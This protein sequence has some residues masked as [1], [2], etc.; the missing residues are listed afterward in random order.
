MSPRFSGCARLEWN[1]F[2]HLSV[3]LCILSLLSLYSL[4][5]CL[6]Y[7]YSRSFV[8]KL[9]FHSMEVLVRPSGLFAQRSHCGRNFNMLAMKFQI[10]IS[11]NYRRHIQD[12]MHVLCLSHLPSKHRWYAE[13]T[14]FMLFCAR[15]YDR[16]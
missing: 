14:S 10:S 11:R 4:P 12:V 7:F 1:G 2:D 6:F 9:I 13:S 5:S 8:R 3:C 16:W 15:P